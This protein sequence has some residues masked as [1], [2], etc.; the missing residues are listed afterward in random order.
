MRNFRKLEVWQ[1]ARSPVKDIYSFTRKL[2]QSE[3]F[4]LI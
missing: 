2:P 4:G 3:K 1:D